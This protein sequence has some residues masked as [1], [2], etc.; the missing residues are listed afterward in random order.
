MNDDL[1]T[2]QATV[3]KTK[4]DLEDDAVSLVYGIVNLIKSLLWI[5]LFFIVCFFV[6]MMYARQ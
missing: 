5:G 6:I 3:K 4:Q 1:D 2:Q